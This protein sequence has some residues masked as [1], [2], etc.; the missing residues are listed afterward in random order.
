MGQD[1]VPGE[2]QV[3]HGKVRADLDLY[4]LASD[5]AEEE[6]LMSDVAQSLDG[7]LRANPAWAMLGKPVTVHN[8]G[9]CRMSDQPSAGVTD[10]EGRVHGCAGL[11][12]LDGS[13]M[14]TSAGVNPSA[15]IV[16]IA[17]R[18]VLRFI[19]TTQPDWPN[20]AAAQGQPGAAEYLE[21]VEGGRRWHA[22]SVA[23]AWRLEP[24]MPAA[25]VP[26]HNDPI[27]LKFLERMGGSYWPGGAP[28]PPAEADRDHDYFALETQGRWDYPLELRLELST[29]NLAEFFED[30]RH[31]LRIAG[32]VEIRLPGDPTAQEYDVVPEHSVMELLV[33]R[34]R[35]AHSHYR[36]PGRLVQGP[37]TERA[38][39]KEALSGKFQDDDA[40]LSARKAV[41]RD[42]TRFMR[43]YVTFMVGE[44]RWLVSG[45]KR[46]RNDPGPDLWRSTAALYC[47]LWSAEP[48]EDPVIRGGGVARLPL[49]DFTREL[50]PSMHVTGT[51]DPARVF[52]AQS[53]FAT[54]FFGSLQR[55]Y[56]PGVSNVGSTLFRTPH[57]RLERPRP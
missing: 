19:R 11:Y 29:A 48:G 21:H 33:P 6:Q 14:C 36:T 17:E 43:Y 10:P 28:V 41:R 39:I 25:A 51:K 16:A 55:I 1:S 38:A 54:Y 35:P 12:V 52:W 8:Q 9:G 30:E 22:R 49:K 45:Y 42:G 20:A 56:V 34:S 57:Q 32:T 37:Q 44:T 27:G 31:R 7:E 53:A 18:N 40:L 46:V 13:L 26:L 15:T 3:R 23:Q 47:S 5:Y 24:P 4:E 50:L 2:L